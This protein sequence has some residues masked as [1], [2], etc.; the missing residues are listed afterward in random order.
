ESGDSATWGPWSDGPLA[1]AEY[2][3]KVTSLANGSYDWE[4]DG[5]SRTTANSHFI[6]VIAGNAVPSHPEGTGRGHFSIA[7]ETG[8]RVNPVDGA[9]DK[10]VA[11]V[12]H[13]L[14]AR[15]PDMQ[16]ASTD[17]Q[18]KPV[19]AHYTYAEAAD[20]SGNMTLSVHADTNDP[21]TAKEDA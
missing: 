6:T 3:L 21:G 18:G 8:K 10:G 12:A 7:F 1:P 20:R 13:D 4:L 14:P 15:T 11:D 5:R 2:Q 16:I 17:D 19:D 9:N